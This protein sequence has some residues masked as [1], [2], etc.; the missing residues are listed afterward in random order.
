MKRG[1]SYSG[2]FVS[3]DGPDGGGKTTQIEQLYTYL[4]GKYEVLRNR[5]PGGTL[6]GEKIRALLLTDG[7]VQNDKRAE[8]FLFEAARAQIAHDIAIP[9]LE[10]GR[11]LLFDRF[12]D[13]TIAYQ[14]YGSGLDLDFIKKANLFASYNISPDI[15]FMIDVPE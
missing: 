14:G 12:F 4:S 9:V 10:S 6:L 2:L 15:T 5:E 3:F 11:V 1:H 8:M 7:S 13:S